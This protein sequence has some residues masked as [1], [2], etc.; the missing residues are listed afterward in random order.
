MRVACFDV[1][2]LLAC[3]F[4]TAA[5][6]CPCGC[7]SRPAEGTVIQ[8]TGTVTEKQKSKVESHYVDRHKKAQTKEPVTQ[9][10]R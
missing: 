8:E 5:L 1:S 9:R 7:D 2:Y 4:L 3:A 10:R 6:G